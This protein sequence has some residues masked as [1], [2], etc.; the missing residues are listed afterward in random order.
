MYEH[1]SSVT[2]LSL[3]E[4]RFSTGCI[5]TIW[6][7]IATSVEK[8]DFD[9]ESK[10]WHCEVIDV[11]FELWIGRHFEAEAGKLQKYPRIPAG[12]FVRGCW[13]FGSGGVPGVITFAGEEDP[14]FATAAGILTEAL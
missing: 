7:K 14:I 6:G 1:A 5:Q 10:I 13:L 8:G 3:S 4:P 2:F 12:I 9:V 11:A